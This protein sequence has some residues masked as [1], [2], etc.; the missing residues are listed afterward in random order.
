MQN[1]LPHDHPV[2]PHL[3]QLGALLA[4]DDGRTVASAD[5]IVKP[6]GYVIPRSASDVHGIT[7]EIAEKYG[8][9]LLLVVGV[10][11][12]LRAK[13]DKIVAHNLPFDERIMATA[14][15]RTG[16]KV[17]LQVPTQ[18]ACTMEMAEPIMKIPATAKMVAAGYGDKF[19]KP[20]LT[21][22]YR[23]FFDEEL[24]GAHSAI[25]DARACAKVYFQIVRTGER[26]EKTW[27]QRFLE[28]YKWSCF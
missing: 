6:E 22:C 20:N 12:N 13:A 24:E 19:K 21:E 15:H 1:N 5:L 2:Q 8:L 27:L 3:V 4:D 18:R 10:F 14:I 16:R 28:F 9:P 25:I 17:T 23:Y 7:T 26:G 11:V